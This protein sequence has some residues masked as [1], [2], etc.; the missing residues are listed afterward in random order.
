MDKVA[1]NIKA[2][3]HA[4][5][6]TQTQFASRY[7]IPLS[8]LKN[9]ESGKHRP[10]PYVVELLSKVVQM[11]RMNRRTFTIPSYDPTKEKLPLREDY[12][13]GIRWLNDVSKVLGHDFV[14][15]LDSAL[16]A[17]Q[18]FLGHNHKS[19]IYGYG[20]VTLTR[21]RGVVILGDWISEYAIEHRHGL[22]YTNFNRTLNDALANEAILDL[23]GITEALSDYYFEHHQSF[24]GLSI[25]PQYQK[26]F[27]RLALDAIT[28]YHNIEPY[29]NASASF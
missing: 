27:E 3:R 23:Q 13:G 21:Y 6:D 24:I 2:L 9:W 26:E 1:M 25:D 12:R 19:T 5:G 16:I 7:H 14:F 20:D 4:L 17:Q 29:Q 28:Y 22:N 10:A 11:D 18:T 8:T 15:A